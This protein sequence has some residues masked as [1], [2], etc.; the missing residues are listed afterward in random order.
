MGYLE[1]IVVV[2]IVFFLFRVWIVEIKLKSELDFRRRYF[3]RFFS[4]YTCLALA[5]G[6]SVYPLNIMVMIAFPILLVTSVWDINFIRKF[7]TQEHWA[8]KKN[9]AILERLTLHPP[10][11]ILAIL[12]ILFDARNYIQPPN[13][14][15]MAFSIAILFIP[16]FIIDERW[17][18]RYKWPEALIVIGLFFGSSV[19]LLI[20]EA[21]LW[22]VPIW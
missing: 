7:Q 14:I 15:L 20:S 1:I 11:V 9:W 22:G 3:S 18:K 6:L 21:L 5:F 16:F 2:G 10:V 13:L 12:M 19:S 17:T 4:Y 8:Q